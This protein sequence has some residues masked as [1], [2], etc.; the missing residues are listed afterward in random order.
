MREDKRNNGDKIINYAEKLMKPLKKY[1]SP[2]KGYNFSLAKNSKQKTE[3]ISIWIGEIL[4]EALTYK[5]VNAVK[6]LT[7]IIK[8]EIEELIKNKS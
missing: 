1:G 8:T 3:V 2:K 6:S 4:F 7:E 5:D